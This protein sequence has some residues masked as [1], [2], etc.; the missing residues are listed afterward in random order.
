[1]VNWA[2]KVQTELVEYIKKVSLDSCSYINHTCR[3]IYVQSQEKLRKFLFFAMCIVIQL[4]NVN[5]QM[6]TFQ[7]NILIQFLVSSTCFEHHVFIIRKNIHAVFYSIFTYIYVSS[8][9]G[10]RCTQYCI[11]YILH[12]LDMIYSMFVH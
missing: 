3:P 5:Q 1:M 11:K 7:T 9:A 10:G 12:L 4:C 2:L 6:H 8:L